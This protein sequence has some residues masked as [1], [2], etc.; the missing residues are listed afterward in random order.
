MTELEL[1]AQKYE[2]VLKKILS[3]Y[4]YETPENNAYLQ[5]SKEKTERRDFS[6]NGFP[7]FV[8]ELVKSTLNP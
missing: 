6:K 2:E 7:E 1:K 3:C 4:N 5:W 8:F